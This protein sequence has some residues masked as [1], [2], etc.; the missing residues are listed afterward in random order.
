[1][2]KKLAKIKAKYGLGYSE[3][4]EYIKWVEQENTR[5]LMQSLFGCRKNCAECK[6]NEQEYD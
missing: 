4:P 3:T 2:D 6:E 5:T 1:M